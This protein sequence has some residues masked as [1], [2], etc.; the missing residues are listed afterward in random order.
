MLGCILLY[1]SCIECYVYCACVSLSFS[2]ILTCI[3]TCICF[4]NEMDYNKEGQQ[5]TKKPKKNQNLASHVGS[6]H[7]ATGVSR[8]MF[9]TWFADLETS[10]KHGSKLIPTTVYI[11]STN[12]IDF[13]HRAVPQRQLAYAACAVVVLHRRIQQSGNVVPAC[14]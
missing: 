4:A 13:T 11:F 5:K 12:S 7:V 6:R 2:Y 3:L 8:S 9:Y 10:I 14:L 1:L